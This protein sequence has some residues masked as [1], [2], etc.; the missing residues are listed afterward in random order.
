M[1]LTEEAKSSLGS[2]GGSIV[3]NI[4]GGVTGALGTIST[5]INDFLDDPFA[6]TEAAKTALG[7]IGSK[8]VSTIKSAITASGGIGDALRAIVVGGINEVID[9]I[10]ALV[11]SINAIFPLINLPKLERL[12]EGILNFVGG[13]AIVGERGPE[14]INLPRG[15]NVFPLNSPVNATTNNISNVEN[16]NATTFNVFILDGGFGGD[17]EGITGIDMAQLQVAAGVGR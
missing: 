12:Q 9:R 4:K 16:S 17:A 10:N 13:T 3:S 2:L 8:I 5:A 11:D 15:T 7:A 14:L 6:F 1:G